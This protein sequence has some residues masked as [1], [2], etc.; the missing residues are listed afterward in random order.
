[1]QAFVS[2]QV[3]PWHY[4]LQD[5]VVYLHPAKKKEKYIYQENGQENGPAVYATQI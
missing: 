2:L 1:M 3:W 4:Q 5:Q